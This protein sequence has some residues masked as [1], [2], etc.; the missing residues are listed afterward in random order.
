MK[1]YNSLMEFAL[2]GKDDEGLD[3]NT[4]KATKIKKQNKK[5]LNQSFNRNCSEKPSQSG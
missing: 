4:M 1:K 5:S 2:F 3:L